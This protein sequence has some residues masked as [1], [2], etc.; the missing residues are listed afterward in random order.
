MRKYLT[1]L[2]L[3]IVCLFP[4]A[5]LAATLRVE[6]YIDGK[7]QLLI[8]DGEVY[9]YNLEKSPPGIPQNPDEN[10]PTVLNGLDWLPIWNDPPCQDCASSVYTNLCPRLGTSDQTVI[11]NTLQARGSVSIFQQPSSGNQHELIV[12]FNDPVGGGAWY[13][14]ELAYDGIPCGTP[15][16]IPTLSEWA[17]IFLALS[18]MGMAGWYWRR[19]QA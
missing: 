16:P 15:T 2:S 18:L 9:W 4:L 11:L 19:R 7:S 14:I 1:A 6:A 13:I 17:Q 12:E 10:F 5:S 8:Q 3:A